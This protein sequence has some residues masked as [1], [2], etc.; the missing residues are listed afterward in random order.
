MEAKIIKTIK[1]DD[2]ALKMQSNK[3]GKMYHKSLGGRGYGAVNFWDYV[4]TFEGDE[5]I[6]KMTRTSPIES[7]TNGLKIGD[8]VTFKQTGDRIKA[9]KIHKPK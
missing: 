4:V 5:N 6:Y 8:S 9:V 1:L 3:Y 2:G 7:T